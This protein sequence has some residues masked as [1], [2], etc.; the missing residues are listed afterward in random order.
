MKN[1]QKNIVGLFMR[2]SKKTPSRKLRINK[3][4]QP[5]DMDD[6]DEFYP[7]G[8]FEFNITK[9]LAFIK[10]NPNTFQSEEVSIKHVRKFPFKNLNESTIQSANISE[11]IILAEISPDKFNVIDGNHRL[12]RAHRD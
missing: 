5:V 1:I 6:G 7:N 3:K 4:F 2:E 9:L 10:A 12:E 8:V 11:P